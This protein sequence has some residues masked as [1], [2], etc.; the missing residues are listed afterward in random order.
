MSERCKNCDSTDIVEIQGQKFCINCGEPYTGSSQSAIS[1]AATSAPTQLEADP[2]ATAAT[3]VAVKAVKSPKKVAP[4]KTAVSLNKAA[5]VAPKK[6]ASDPG[7]EPA[8]PITSKLP[9]LNL[10]Y[11]ERARP[12]AVARTTE[13][14][15]EKPTE[16]TKHVAL[17]AVDKP[18]DSTVEPIRPDH[19]PEP[20]PDRRPHPWG[21]S[22]KVALWMATPIALLIGGLVW[23]TIDLDIILYV[24]AAW[25]VIG[26]ITLALAQS[27]IL[28]GMSRA[29]DHRPVP[30]KQWWKAARAGLMDVLNIDV[31]T[32]IIALI[33]VGA[34]AAGWQGVDRLGLSGWGEIAALLVVNSLAAWFILGAAVARHMAIPAS[35]IGGMSSTEAYVLGWKTFLKAGGSLSLA[36]VQAWMVRIIIVVAAVGVAVYLNQAIPDLNHTTAT[37]LIGGAIFAFTLLLFVSALQ[38]ETRIWLRHYRY[39]IARCFPRRQLRLLAG[40][41]QTLR[42]R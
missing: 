16:T 8:K 2:A 26:V 6:P 27:A 37:L 38:L 29:Y 33:T 34:A 13:Q 42:H 39:W 5:K 23:F 36:L 3:S 32:T 28:Y 15:A 18:V 10:R 12:G 22:F 31:M 24:A 11:E 9:P 21:F 7:P 35:V 20:A 41:V 14:P 4:K 25:T 1:S 17:E 19:R 40:R 30:R